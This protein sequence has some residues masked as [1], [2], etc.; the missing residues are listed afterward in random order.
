MRGNGSG[1]EGRAR[2]FIPELRRPCRPPPA[3]FAA[4]GS[5]GRMLRPLNARPERVLMTT[6]AVG[7]VWTYALDLAAGLAAEG[8]ETRLVGLGPRPSERQL[9][10]A[11]AA[12]FAV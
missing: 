3:P 8:I 6:D 10:A 2:E 1:H 5:G 12:G 11:R 7:G 9:E 4:R